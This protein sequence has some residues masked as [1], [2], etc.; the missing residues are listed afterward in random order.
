MPT[1]P[2]PSESPTGSIRLPIAPERC[3]K[4]EIATVRLDPESLSELD[5]G[6][7]DVIEI[8]GHDRTVA[9]VWRLPK[10][11][12][13]NGIARANKFTRRNAGL[14]PGNI[15]TFHP[16]NLLPVERI[17]LKPTEQASGAIPSHGSTIVKHA[18]MKQPVSEQDLIPLNIKYYGSG[19]TPIQV[20]TVE[21]NER[22]VIDRNTIV[23]LR[24]EE[25]VESASQTSGECLL[26]PVGD[27][28]S[29][30][31]E[32]MTN[33]LDTHTVDALSTTLRKENADALARKVWQDHQET[34]A[35]RTEELCRVF[36]VVVDAGDISSAFTVLRI[37]AVAAS[38]SY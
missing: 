34:R 36:E 22:G 10:S 26:S 33:K 3:D 7:G 30:G 24:D 12:W 16:V 2:E 9:T 37:F 31:L 15:A 1:N 5:A 38:Y 17:V 32:Y 35:L 13:G 28:Q 6:P 8:E 29:D 18:L 20:A 21:P 14:D 23:N 25:P 27:S 4:L 11:D 19:I